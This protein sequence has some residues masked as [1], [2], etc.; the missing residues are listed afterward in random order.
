MPLRR[1]E[2]DRLAGVIAPVSLVLG[3]LMLGGCDARLAP[4]VPLFGAYFPSWL[5]CTA[6][7]VIGA[8]ILRGLFIRIGLDDVLPWRLAA[9]ASLAAAI[10]FLLALTVYGR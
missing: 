1:V 5:V 7:G 8:V 10:G 9:Y 3:A 6:A 4:A 2:W